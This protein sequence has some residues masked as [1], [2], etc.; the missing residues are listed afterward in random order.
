MERNIIKFQQTNQALVVKILS[1]VSVVVSRLQF[2]SDVRVEVLGVTRRQQVQQHFSR[3]LVLRSRKDVLE[4][5]CEDQLVEELRVVDDVTE[6]KQ[7][8]MSV[9]FATD[10]R[11]ERLEV[12]HDRLPVLKFKKK[13]IIKITERKE[14]GVHG[15]DCE[16]LVASRL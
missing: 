15:N 1:P 14:G 16:D 10:L 4:Q 6:C 2:L 13:I 12:L 9:L 8:E 7:H 3:E 5:L 11:H